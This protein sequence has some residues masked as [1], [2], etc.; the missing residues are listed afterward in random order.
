M[1]SSKSINFSLRGMFAILILVAF[2]AYPGRTALE[3][4]QREIERLSDR[5]DNWG[6][7][8]PFIYGGWPEFFG[9]WR[10]SLILTQLT[11]TTLGFLLLYRGI[12]LG[13]RKY[14]F[15]FLI[16]FFV[17]AMFSI[18]LWRDAT[19]FSIAILGLG[20]INESFSHTRWQ[21]LIFLSSGITLTLFAGMFKPIF[22]LS[23]A[24]LIIW[25][26]WQR[27]KKFSA[28]RNLILAFCIFFTSTTPYLLD[29]RLSHE[30]N[31]QK[32]YPQQQPILLDLA[33]NYC[34][35]Q[36][37]TI[38]NDAKNLLMP[39]LKNGYPV[40]SVCAATN[41]FRWDDLHSDPKNWEYSSPII[42]IT[43]D[44]SRNVNN[45]V[46]SW[47]MLILNHPIDWIQVRLLFVGPALVMSNSFV[48]E[49]SMRQDQ[50][51]IGP[52]MDALWNLLSS[53][54]ETIDKFRL[55]S[56]LFLIV[57]ALVTLT[58]SRSVFTPSDNWRVRNLHF[59][60]FCSTFTWFLAVLTFLAPNGRYV[61]PYVLI[62]Y[63][64]LLR[65]MAYG[66][67]PN[68]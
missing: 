33:M 30:F 39:L 59:S 58:R 55:T 29:T 10:F 61:L 17:S 49:D 47:I 42:R 31:L 23:L 56:L 26:T 19:L 66:V 2:S 7:I 65:A 37:E 27:R 63:V 41:P 5:S 53:I 15:G 57:C 50:Y 34:W 32:V 16:L 11:F 3:G 21:K 64:L 60:L 38:R 67:D 8:T 24:P 62:N 40:E 1:A 20:L 48:S 4:G 45:L 22:A 68:K 43:G 54:V 6:F 25:L 44:K 36:G 35:G 46:K 52:V 13:S 51:V 14:V 9:N 18:Q 12:N 28:F